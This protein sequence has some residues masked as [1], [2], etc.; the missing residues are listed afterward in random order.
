MNIAIKEAK[1]GEGFVNPNPLVGA[2]L[3]KNN[4]IIGTGFHEYYGGLHAERNA[5]ENAIK[6]SGNKKICNG[7]SLFVTLEPCCHKGKQP[8][9]TDAIIENKIKEVYIGSKDPNPLVNGKG[10]KILEKNGIKVF[11]GIME[12]ECD[13]LNPFFFHYI[14]NKTPYVILKMAMS[15]NGKCQ[16]K[17]SDKKISS[18]ES[19][20][21]VHKNRARVQAVMVSASTVNSDDC[22]LSCRLE[23]KHHQPIKVVLDTN[24][25]IKT[26]RKLFDDVN[27]R[28]II[29]YSKNKKLKIKALE[30]KNVELVKVPLKNKHVDLKAVLMELGKRSI[31]SVI[32]E[33]TGKLADA[34]ICEKLVD[35][36]QIYHSSMYLTETEKTNYRLLSTRLIP[37]DDMLL[38]YSCEG[39]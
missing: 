29:F 33:N 22:L 23:G 27:A 1:R 6:I 34:F 17:L 25:K 14:K 4:K 13:S 16:T 39:N 37:G 11:E 30:K 2:V 32:I 26:D 28:T 18:D 5:I 31:D 3:V 15:L 19:H 10:K 35:K 7:A 20:I 12:K 9:C 21:D 36:I 8:P 24:L 38:E